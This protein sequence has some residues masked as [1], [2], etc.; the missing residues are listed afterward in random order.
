[1]KK[2][3]WGLSILFTF[4]CS[5]SYSKEII[6]NCN[7]QTSIYQDL[8]TWKSNYWND[9]PDQII[10]ID[11]NKKVVTINDKET[12]FESGPSTG[13]KSL[14]INDNQVVWKVYNLAGGVWIENTLNRLSGKLENKSYWPSSI[15][16]SSLSAIGIVKYQCF[17]SKKLF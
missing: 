8:T 17:E 5:F 10:K 7:Y 3:F 13:G 2:I 4:I 16:S 14:E 6:L 15:N 12:F 1:M 9:Y 11:F